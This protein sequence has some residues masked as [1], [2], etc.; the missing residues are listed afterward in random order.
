MWHWSFTECSCFRYEQKARRRTGIFFFVF[1]YSVVNCVFSFSFSLR[2]RD[3]SFSEDFAK[4]SSV[5]LAAISSRIGV[6][7]RE[8]VQNYVLDEAF[9][10]DVA[11]SCFLCFFQIFNRHHWRLFLPQ[12]CLHPPFFFQDVFK[13]DFYSVFPSVLSQPQKFP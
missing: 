4:T 5:A 12:V 2:S 6:V 1:C 13:Q 3:S 7:H 9:L 10:A 8:I 11:V